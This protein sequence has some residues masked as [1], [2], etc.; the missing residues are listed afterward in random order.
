MSGRRLRDRVLLILLIA[1]SLYALR[2]AKDSPVMQSGGSQFVA[3]DGDSL[4]R[5]GRDYRLFGIDAPE[6][7]QSCTDRYGVSYA[8][9]QGARKALA[10]LLSGSSLSCSI[11]DVDRYNRAVVRCASGTTDINGEMVRLG[12][13]IAYTRHSFDYLDAERQARSARRGIWQGEFETPEAWR[14]RHR[15]LPLSGNGETLGL[16]PD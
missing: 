11:E 13:A 12:W 16:Q 8:C 10:G 4:R 9:G 15:A 2:H 3:V 7:H 1:G 5:D 14:N 6:L